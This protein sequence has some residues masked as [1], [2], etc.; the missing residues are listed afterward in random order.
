MGLEKAMATSL[1]RTWTT[2]TV[3]DITEKKTRDNEASKSYNVDRRRR[4]DRHRTDT[5][6]L[7]SLARSFLKKKNKKKTRWK[8]KMFNVKSHRI[9]DNNSS[10]SQ[11]NSQGRNQS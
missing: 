8:T 6:E 1:R 9:K 10:K 4:G 5:I 3:L 7:Q 2:A 11:V